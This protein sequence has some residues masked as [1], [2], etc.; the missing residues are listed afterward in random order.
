[1]VRTASVKVLGP[2]A[3]RGSRTRSAG[4]YEELRHDIVGC[5]W[6]PGARLRF[7]EL[8]AHYE[9]GLSPL[10]EALMK[11]ASDGLVQLEEHKG[12]RVSPVSRAGLLDITNMR[13]ELESMAIRLSIANGDDRW[14]AGIVAALH[15]LAKRRKIGAD[16]LVDDEWEARHHAFH[17]ALTAASGSEWL[18]R[19]RSQLYDQADRY[20]RVAIHYLHAP[21]DDLVEH[22]EI[23]DA[24]L[25]RDAEAAV[26]LARRHLERTCQI[27]LSSPQIFGES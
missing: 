3:E 5:R 2:A 24:V 7:E 13:K 22:R 6:K 20:R 25:A 8:K 1:M 15:E 14:E 9:V 10:R 4:V 11:L 16:G 19:F 17:D 18:Q 21:R 27:L 12:F 23:A 26:F